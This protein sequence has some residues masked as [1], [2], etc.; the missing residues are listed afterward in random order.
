MRVAIHQP[1]YIPYLGYFHQIHNSDIFV[2]LDNVTYTKNNYTNRNRIKTPD[3]W[4]WLT[5]PVVNKKI[6]ETPIS[7]VKI[8]NSTNWY[9]KHRNSIKFNYGRAPH[10]EEYK[11]FIDDI[12]C[13]SWGALADL[14]KY[15]IKTICGLLGIN[16]TFV[17]ASELDV[18]GAG[19]DLLVNICEALGAD[20]YFSGRDGRFYLDCQRFEQRGIKVVFQGFP[21]PTYPQLFGAFVP[22]LSVIDY[23]LNDGTPLGEKRYM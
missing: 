14:N 3:G 11:N 13:S 18:D 9:K 16:G 15:S 12:Y 10:F 4:C 7:K 8:D 20:T 22:N 17:N 1:N 5:V 19:T 23:L 2:F 6:L 21:A